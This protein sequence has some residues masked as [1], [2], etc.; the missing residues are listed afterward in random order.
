MKEVMHMRAV[1]FGVL[2]QVAGNVAGPV[3]ISYVLMYGYTTLIVRPIAMVFRGFGILIKK[4]F[5][6]SEIHPVTGGRGQ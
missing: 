3:W 1:D 2:C 4:V 5:G 6:I